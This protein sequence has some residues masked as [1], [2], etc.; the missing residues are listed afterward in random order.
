M[1]KEKTNF[2]GDNNKE[3][4]EDKK[5]SGNK[6]ISIED[7]KNEAKKQIE[8]LADKY[9]YELVNLIIT[10]AKQEFDT[11][12]LEE[13]TK[14]INDVIKK[15]KEDIDA[16]KNIDSKGFSMIQENAREAL[17]EIRTDSNNL[18]NKRGRAV[19]KGYKKVVTVEDLN[20]QKNE[21]DFADYTSQ[22]I[23]DFLNDKNKSQESTSL[24]LKEVKSESVDEEVIKKLAID[25]PELFVDCF[26]EGKMDLDLLGKDWIEFTQKAVDFLLENNNDK[27]VDKFFS[28]LIN[29]NEAS[30]L[31]CKYPK[32]FLK[33]FDDFKGLTFVDLSS[34]LEFSLKEGCF[35]EAV[36]KIK[37]LARYHKNQ[38]RDIEP[39][40]SLLRD[41][42]VSVD[43]LENTEGERVGQE[44]KESEENLSNSVDNNKQEIKD[45]TETENEIVEEDNKKG[46][47][48]IEPKSD[49][50]QTKENVDE[51]GANQE[52]DLTETENEIVEEDNKKGD[53]VIEPK[54]DDDKN[55]DSN[56]KEV[57][58]ELK[59]EG[60]NPD[61]QASDDILN[62]FLNNSGNE[63]DEANIKNEES[64]DVTPD[65]KEEGVKINVNDLENADEEG[66][67]QEKGLSETGNEIVEENNKKGNN[68]IKETENKNKN[69]EENLDKEDGDPFSLVNS[70]DDFY[71]KIDSLGY[72]QINL[73]EG[74]Y[75][76]KDKFIELI[77]SIEDN[78]GGDGLDEIKDKNLINLIK[79]LLNQPV[80]SDVEGSNDDGKNKE[81]LIDDI[82]WTADSFDALYNEI[83]KKIEE[84][85]SISFEWFSTCKPDDDRFNKCRDYI[86]EI[87]AGKRMNKI[88]YKKLK[89]IVNVLLKKEKESKEFEKNEVEKNTATGAGGVGEENKKI[90]NNI[91]TADDYRKMLENFRIEKGGIKGAEYAESEKVKDDLKDSIFILVRGLIGKGADG[92]AD[93]EIEK[94]IDKISEKIGLPSQVVRSVIDNYKDILKTEALSTFNAASSKK[95]FG[96]NIIKTIAYAGTGVLGT[97]SGGIG[98][99]IG[100][101]A[102]R[103][104]DRIS[105]EVWKK[106]KLDKFLDDVKEKKDT[107]D[108]RK[109]IFDDVSASLSLQK[110]IQIN[111]TKIGDNIYI[112]EDVVKSYI[113]EKIKGGDI[114]VEDEKTNEYK[115]K[116]SRALSGLSKI[117]QINHDKED[118][119]K[120]TKSPSFLKKID[121]F[122]A[123]KI[124][125]EKTAS[126]AAASAF[127]FSFA[128]LLAKEVPVI[129]SILGFYTGWRLGGVVADYSIKN[130]Q[131]DFEKINN[132]ININL[133][134]YSKYRKLLLDDKFKNKYP[135]KWLSLKSKIDLFES[136]NIIIEG[137]K[138]D[139]L[140][141]KF[142]DYS[143]TL[144]KE[145]NNQIFK[146]RIIQLATA[147]AG[148]GVVTGIE[149]ISRGNDVENVNSASVKGGNHEPI[150][151]SELDD[152]VV[153]GNRKYVDEITK[154]DNVWNSTKQIFKD[155]AKEFRYNP[156]TDGD[157]DHWANLKTSETIN[158][159]GHLTDKVFAGNRVVLE[160]DADGS[161][162][163]IHIE[164][165]DGFDP[166][167]LPKHPKHLPED[168]GRQTNN[169]NPAASEKTFD[170]HEK[171]S[172]IFDENSSSSPETSPE[173]NPYNPKY[174]DR[175]LH[176]DWVEKFG[177]H[178]QPEVVEDLKETPIVS[179]APKETTPFASSYFDNQ[180]NLNSVGDKHG[181]GEVNWVTR[182]PFYDGPQVMLPSHIEP[183]E[184]ESLYD[185]GALKE[186][187]YIKLN[188]DFRVTCFETKNG[189]IYQFISD[190][191]ETKLN[192]KLNQYTGGQG[193]S[194]SLTD[195][196]GF[197]LKGGG[198][199][200][201]KE[202][203]IKNI[204]AKS[205]IYELIKDK[206]DDFA[207]NL[208]QEI[209]KNKTE[210]EVL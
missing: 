169:S 192:F 21:K 120:K 156:K 142:D 25:F 158:N 123:G 154:G 29:S 82:E 106:K 152:V 179:N 98:F 88:K 125:S 198:P 35:D 112:N 57:R 28:R 197:V 41:F 55:L 131:V 166:G 191:T 8:D 3:G 18:Q 99:P 110:K 114:E 96:F 83:K 195:D 177:D 7:L 30:G 139:V 19:K 15:A 128:G 207:K 6:E 102:V 159:S 116:I 189:H 155:H 165:G 204:E 210:L 90:S 105:T 138:D 97:L 178:H 5:K 134:S 172:W 24:M 130:K 48:V 67:N 60:G 184:L 4:F 74:D 79:K 144:D 76:S 194:I 33:Y 167:Y 206:D 153:S 168:L 70:W 127:A 190:D 145:K 121:D 170:L 89:D 17:E 199:A 22:E 186:N 80:P 187:N 95:I 66:A 183:H 14:E 188:D 122:L 209:L 2:G 171:S 16:V 146:K 133:D 85:Y 12:K 107:E 124:S 163:H 208:Q 10:L 161:G 81:H 37:D 201:T 151:K 148:M 13:L 94:E 180:E 196:H 202:V 31:M 185:L 100:I 27:V 59:K 53:D 87:R 149:C 182:N 23:L 63:T 62:E 44:A 143:E 1:K 46:D 47:D 93:N 157:L 104:I 181:L 39:F 129:R 73:G 72:D 117:D 77:K 45:L 132:D 78:N 49:D 200:E 193:D 140:S 160:A 42:K 75:L 69:N 103:V 56:K 65:V 118:Q 64:V 147:A 71:D 108:G 136:K 40:Y 34:V 173:F 141:K 68:A 11:R 86:E 58:D 162:Q 176:Q 164:K 43:D 113:D 51:E 119:I 52:K 20:G 101:F 150:Y 32:F 175:A 84:G 50:K 54:S 111:A 38:G 92:K 174:S 9:N 203:L 135:D 137:S 26:F 115:E 126:V 36:F 205:K 91:D 61:N 109:K